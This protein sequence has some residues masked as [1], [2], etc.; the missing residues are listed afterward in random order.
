M[1]LLSSFAYR[2]TLQMK[3]L[4]DRKHAR[5]FLSFRLSPAKA[6]ELFCLLNMCAISFRLSRLEY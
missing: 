2:F 1:T 4:I 3:W 6:E 5:A